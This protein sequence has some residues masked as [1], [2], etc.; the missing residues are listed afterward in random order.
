MKK[1]TYLLIALFLLII[2]S[3]TLVNAGDFLVSPSLVNT[4][5]FND[6]S[7]DHPNY[8][9]IEH[10]KTKNIIQGYDDG[11]FKPDKSINR[12]EF[13]KIVM[14]ATLPTEAVG[15]NC[16]PDVRDQWFAKY[17]C[18][19]RSLGIIRGYPDGN[20]KPSNEINFVEASK[21]IVNTFG[22]SVGSDDIWYKPFV[23]KL[24]EKK[25]IPITISAFNANITRGEMA[26]MVYRLKTDITEKESL[27]YE[28]IG[29]WRTYR[30]E[31]LGFELKIP[32]Y[33]NVEMELND[34]YN[35]VTIFEGNNENFE[36]RL[37]S[38]E[39][40]MSGEPIPLDEYLF[41]DFPIAF[42]ASL[43]GEEALVFEAPNGY[44][45]GPSCGAP[46][47]AYSAKHK[48]SFYNLVFYG[49]TELTVIEKL[50]L[51]SFKFI[52]SQPIP[53]EIEVAKNMKGE[54]SSIKVYFST[55]K[56]NEGFL[57]C[58]KTE[59]VTMLIPKTKAL[60]EAALKQLFLGPTEEERAEGHKEF[61]INKELSHN[62]KRVFIKNNTAYLDWKDFRQTI[63]N[64]STSCGSQSFYA[65]IDATLKQ[66]P[67][68]SNIVHAIDGKPAVFYDWMQVGCDLPIHNGNYCDDTPY[69]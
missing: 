6:V 52:S 22:Y 31:E 11:T 57:D 3:L 47:V 15:S 53:T 45:D 27:N 51:S 24:G 9:A 25:A 28:T 66:F 14:K 1:T 65:P 18:N 44:C 4:G 13:T 62:L 33:V 58:G 63:G 39:S 10:V 12:A 50:I 17:V 60:A 42:R 40:R 2:V 46:F 59:G 16:F 69:K 32:S 68:I 35:R 20:F 48:D 30:N 43:G 19:A 64:A 8:D 5:S 41:L 49:D 26:E 38:G 21:I 55:L 36:V 34:A 54:T 37:K 29:E 56:D 67:S 61:W 7:L 23:E